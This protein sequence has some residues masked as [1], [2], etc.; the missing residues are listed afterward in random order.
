MCFTIREHFSTIVTQ[1]EAP[2]ARQKRRTGP[3]LSWTQSSEI[4]Q[5]TT[6]TASH[7]RAELDDIERLVATLEPLT[8]GVWLA[9][10]LRTHVHWTLMADRLC[11][12]I[13]SPESRICRA[14]GLVTVCSPASEP[15]FLIHERD[16]LDWLEPDRILAVREL[17]DEAC[18]IR[19]ERLDDLDA[20]LIDAFNI[21]TQSDG[22]TPRMI[23]VGQSRFVQVYDDQLPTGD[24]DADAAFRTIESTIDARRRLVGPNAGTREV[25]KQMA[26]DLEQ[27]LR[28]G[29][30][31]SY[32]WAAVLHEQIAGMRQQLAA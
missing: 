25:L 19:L 7:V 29:K 1:V 2:P 16:T 12:V 27:V 3:A 13:E 5:M 17:G 32:I 30:I 24:P 28:N 15:V 9:T 8:G 4:G 21:C 26:C 14:N 20:R 10:D 31:R 22:P 18:E 23:G 6:P 11:P